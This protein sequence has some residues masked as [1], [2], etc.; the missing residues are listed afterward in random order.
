MA[1]KYNCRSHN[2]GIGHGGGG[3]HLGSKI[4]TTLFP[5]ITK[6]VRTPFS[7]TCLEQNS[8]GEPYL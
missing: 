5:V 8:V 6:I 1:E 4:M 2:V 7:D 3:E